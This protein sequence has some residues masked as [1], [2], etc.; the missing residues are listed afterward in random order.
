MPVIVELSS[1]TRKSPYETGN[2]L[3][4]ASGLQRLG[5]QRAQPTP[6]DCDQVIGENTAFP[7]YSTEEQACH[8]S[9]SFLAKRHDLAFLGPVYPVSMD[10]RQCSESNFERW[11]RASSLKLSMSFASLQE[12]IGLR[13]TAGTRLNDWFKDYHYTMCRTSLYSTLVRISRFDS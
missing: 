2:L 9:T 5:L 10:G 11:W 12:A 7:A 1:T 3:G 8:L 13:L 4:F 6:F